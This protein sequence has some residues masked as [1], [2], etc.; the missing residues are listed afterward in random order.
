MAQAVSLALALA[1]ALLRAARGTSPVS[2]THFVRMSRDSWGLL[3]I[4][5]EFLGFP[6]DSDGFQR[7]P[8][9]FLGIPRNH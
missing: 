3:G 1:L 7:I 2:L 8:R 6:R 9:V 5:R 4:P